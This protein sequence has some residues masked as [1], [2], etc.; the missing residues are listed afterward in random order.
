MRLSVWD[1]GQVITCSLAL[2]DSLVNLINFG[3]SSK[4]LFVMLLPGRWW[5]CHALSRRFG[6]WLLLWGVSLIFLGIF[7][8][9]ALQTEF[10]EEFQFLFPSDLAHDCLTSF[11]SLRNRSFDWIFIVVNWVNF[12]FRRAYRW[13]PLCLISHLIWCRCSITAPHS[14]WR[15]RCGGLQRL[16]CSCHGPISLCFLNNLLLTSLHLESHGFKHS[17]LFLCHNRS[18][19]D[20]ISPSSHG[21]LLDVWPFSRS[22]WTLLSLQATGWRCCLSCFNPNHFF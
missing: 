4:D 9:L 1:H 16:S 2:F 10:I 7:K 6:S 22:R 5:R 18:T 13:W 21:Y 8:T 19:F 17:L 3:H 12:I 14:R 11:N 15:N 20:L